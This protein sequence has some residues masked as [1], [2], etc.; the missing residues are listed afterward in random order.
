MKEE[1]LG[2]E[3]LEA[4]EIDDDFEEEDKVVIFSQKTYSLI[5]PKG[6]IGTMQVKLWDKVRECRGTKCPLLS[7]CPY[8]RLRSLE[9]LKRMEE[10]GL[11]LGQCRVE[12]KYLYHIEQ[13][14]LK[15]A[16]MAKDEFV[17]Q[18]IG[19]H[20]VPLYHDLCLLKMKKA[21]LK[22]IEYSDSKGTKRIHPVFDQIEKTH[23]AILKTWKGS[24]LQ[25]IAKECGFFKVGG[26]V[27]AGDPLD[28]EYGLMSKGIE[29][30]GGPLKSANPAPKMGKKKKTDKNYDGMNDGLEGI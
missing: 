4:D 26:M 8:F 21:E 6:H 2:P 29:T 24:G 22:E 9:K 25:D 27:P 13:P 7:S 10:E 23:A 3:D 18:L 19:M 5:V 17:M 16:Q 1:D 30:K 28:D 14:L 12:Q 20:L 15:L 11:P